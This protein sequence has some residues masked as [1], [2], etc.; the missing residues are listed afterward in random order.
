MVYPKKISGH[1]KSQHSMHKER[2]EDIVVSPKG[3]I[4]PATI[5]IKGLP[6]R[7]CRKVTKRL[8]D[9][10]LRTHHITNGSTKLSNLMR[11]A[12]P[13]RKTCTAGSPKRKEG[14]V[15]TECKDRK[16]KDMIVI[17]SSEDEDIKTRGSG[18][19]VSLT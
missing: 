14:K 10:L 7:K 17:S 13:F 16:L 5:K 6:P 1:M 18:E 15:K 9:H 8:W 3:Y 2:T 4:C 19:P 11:K 12:E